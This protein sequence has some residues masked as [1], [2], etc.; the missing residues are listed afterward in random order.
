MNNSRIEI[1]KKDKIK[2]PL[3][4]TFKPVFSPFKFFIHNQLASGIFLVM[5]TLVALAWANSEYSNF[6]HAINELVFSISLGEYQI[7]HSLKHWMNDGLMVFFF[8]VLGLEIKRE[9]LVGELKDI[10][11]S[12][13]VILMACGGM[14]VP[15]LIY[16]VVISVAQ[17]TPQ[18]WGGWGIPMATDAAF[19]IVLLTMLGKRIP[20]IIIVIVT[21]LAIVDDLGAVLV[22]SLFYSDGLDPV[23]LLYSLLTVSMIVAFNLT[24]IRHFSFYL[25]G[26]IVLWW[27][28][29]H[30]GIHA[31]TA[32]II[33]ALLVPTK[34]HAKTRWFSRQMKNI[35]KRFDKI[36]HPNKSIL[37]TEEQHILAEQAQK[38]ALKT[39]SPIQHWSSQLEKPVSFIIIPL[40]AL[41]NAGVTIPIG[42][43][44]QIDPSVF[45]AV[46]AGLV[47][48]KPLGIT[49]FSW[50]GLK[51]NLIKLPKGIN[52]IHIT[53]IGFLAGIGF[54]MSLF[55]A[56]LAFEHQAT[57]LLQSKF[58][59]LISSSIAALAGTLFL[60]LARK[61]VQNT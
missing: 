12:G 9:V 8:F 34:P 43:L 16:I 26:G 49:L 40:F 41:L 20:P 53:G 14:I 44:E 5:A 7:S 46:S 36:D 17:G 60:L 29:S 48:G 58:A 3:E 10:K 30:S 18:S 52:F 2:A 11:K 54:T 19:A 50:I 21:A 25:I 4:D 51:L 39:A 31:T 57:M 33:S 22:I 56:S 6:Y 24:G 1:N 32:G 37:E 45:I 38:V 47:I 55:I 13:L 15:A 42:R 27:S 59:I 35:I 23:S 28:I 61:T